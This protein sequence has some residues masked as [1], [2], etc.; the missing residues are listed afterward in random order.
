M[1]TAIYRIESIRTY[2]SEHYLDRSLHTKAGHAGDNEHNE[3]TPISHLYIIS[4][5][6]ATKVAPRKLPILISIR[7]HKSGQNERVPLYDDGFGISTLSFTSNDSEFKELF[8][9]DTPEHITNI[10]F[11]K[12]HTCFECIYEENP[13][14]LGVWE[15]ATLASRFDEEVCGQE[16]LYVG[17][18]VG[19]SGTRTSSDRLAEHSTLQKI[20]SDY[21]NLPGWEIFITLLKFNVEYNTTFPQ[22][23]D[24]PSRTS[25]SKKN[26]EISSPPLNILQETPKIQN[27]PLSETTLSY[28]TNID[29]YTSIIESML[30]SYFRPIYNT[31]YISWNEPRR[32]YVKELAKADVELV[33]LEFH[34]HNSLA[35]FFSESIPLELCHYI[36]GILPTTEYSKDFPELQN[37]S[38]FRIK[39]ESRYD[40]LFLLVR[41]I[42]KS[43]EFT[44]E[45]SHGDV[46]PRRDT[47]KILSSLGHLSVSYSSS[48]HNQEIPIIDPPTHP[49][50]IVLHY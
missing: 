9:G 18:S 14:K 38:D 27:A 20:L 48:S 33:L 1:R 31:H 4:R 16:I 5:R 32:K 41:K 6:P 3:T 29:N 34:S 8:I 39:A 49:G 46:L 42:K 11:N 43:L 13:I 45:R 23:I 50:D 35:C 15:F 22:I 7:S 36:T 21:S 28:I 12:K 26:L 10:E 2:S 24:T 47:K 37:W 40:K 25:T 19:N 30:I 44:C 17:K